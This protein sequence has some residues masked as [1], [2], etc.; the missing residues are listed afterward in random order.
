VTHL[1]SENVLKALT[2]NCTAVV[3]STRHIANSLPR[4]PSNIIITQ[5]K[6]QGPIP[7]KSTP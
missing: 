4:T 3:P 6:I 5:R 2:E 1:L 7:P